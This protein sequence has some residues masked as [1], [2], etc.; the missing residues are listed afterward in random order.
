MAAAPFSGWPAAGANTQ[1]RPA[2]QTLDL[3]ALHLPDAPCD[4]TDIWSGEPLGTFKNRFYAT[5][6]AHGALLLRITS[7]K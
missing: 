7:S 5:V 2:R 4:L 6:P 1:D 3:T